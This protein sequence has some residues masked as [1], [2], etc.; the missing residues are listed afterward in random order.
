MLNTATPY[1]REAGNTSLCSGRGLCT[2]RE[3]V[4]GSG[5]ET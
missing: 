2:E 4:P 1:D 5:V 3:R